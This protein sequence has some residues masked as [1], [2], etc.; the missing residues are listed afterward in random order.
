MTAIECL[1]SALRGGDHYQLA[2]N[3][4]VDD[5]RRASPEERLRMVA[6]PITRMGHLEGLVASVVSALCRET[7]TPPPSW[8]ERIGSPDPF[9]AFP[10]K[11]YAMRVRLMMESPAPFKIRN[12]FVPRD[13]LARA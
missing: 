8:L 7:E 11:S 5:F 3:E 6:L 2:I 4:F 1:E 9:F 12:V 13:Y 10:A